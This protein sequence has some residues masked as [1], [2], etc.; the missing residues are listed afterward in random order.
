VGQPDVTSDVIHCEIQTSPLLGNQAKNT[1]LG[2][3]KLLD[4]IASLQET[5]GTDITGSNQLIQKLV[6]QEFSVSQCY[7]YSKR[8]KKR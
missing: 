5:Q 8:K 6:L 7:Y 3:I 1:F 4:V 2:S